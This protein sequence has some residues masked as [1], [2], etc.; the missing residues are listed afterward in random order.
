M[1]KKKLKLKI[2]EGSKKK[3]LAS[4]KKVLL[5]L[6]IGIK[7]KSTCHGLS[8]PCVFIC[9]ARNTRPGVLFLF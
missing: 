7:K 6:K 5:A 9:F 3:I 1:E 2:S 8:I 4:K